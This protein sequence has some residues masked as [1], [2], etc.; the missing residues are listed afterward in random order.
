[1]LIYYI[2]VCDESGE[3]QAFFHISKQTKEI[4]NFIAGWAMNDANYRP[5]YM[6]E[7]LKYLGA[8]VIRI[9]W[10]DISFNNLK[11]IAIE[12]LDF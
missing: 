2:D 5:E 1:M 6:E 3:W 4:V 7:L 11:Q 8:E 10:D 12:E 9:D